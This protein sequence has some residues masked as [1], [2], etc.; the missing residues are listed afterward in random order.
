MRIRR[1]LEKLNP[2]REALE[3]QSALLNLGW[4]DVELSNGEI[5]TYGD[6][7]IVLTA[8]RKTDNIELPSIVIMNDSIERQADRIEVVGYIDNDDD[9]GFYWESHDSQPGEF[10]G[11]SST[12]MIKELEAVYGRVS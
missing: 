11:L 5:S 7:T 12:E 10:N 9:D 1:L 3:V 4:D 2:R 6:N 8:T